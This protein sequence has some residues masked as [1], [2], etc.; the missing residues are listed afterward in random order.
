MSSAVD[1]M[2]R[3][4]SRGHKNPLSPIPCACDPTRPPP[5]GVALIGASRAHCDR[6][7]E[8]A[9]KHARDFGP[10]FGDA[11]FDVAALISDKFIDRPH[12]D[13]YARDASGR[14]LAAASADDIP[15]VLGEKGLVVCAN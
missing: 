2:A 1:E 14:A 11:A 12:R 4:P 8:L 9:A 7:N 5:R 6:G 10:G 3:Y 15:T 13:L